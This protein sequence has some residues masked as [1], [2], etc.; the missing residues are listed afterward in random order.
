M[1][2]EVD[3]NGDTQLYGIFGYPVKHS[4]SP[5]FQTSAFSCLNIPA[6]YL[7]FEIKPEDLQK[8]VE[9]IK[10]FNIKGVNITVPHKEEVIGYLNEISEEVKYIK[11]CNTIK[12]ID[13]YL[14]GYNTDAYGFI[15]GLKE[16]I[17]DLKGKNILVLGAGGASRAVIYSLI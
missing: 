17:S 7:P 8:A 14:I 13:G 5:Q 4:K 1:K 10:I 9:A 12:N 2:I 16:L 15:T 11:A 3:I 6:V